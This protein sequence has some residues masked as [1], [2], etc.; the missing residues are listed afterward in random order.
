MKP[1]VRMN[2]YLKA[3]LLSLSIWI[4]AILM[5]TVFVMVWMHVFD[6]EELTF[7]MAG[8]IIYLSVVFSSPGFL[9][10]L[11][12]S[13]FQLKNKEL[14]TIL[15]VTAFLG[16]V[17]ACVILAAMFTAELNRLSMIIVISPAAVTLLSVGL[18]K[19]VIDI[20]TQKISINN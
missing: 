16:A 2:P 9:V 7:D 3:A 13:I 17:L 12:I 20:I 6:G 1:V 8:F 5:N 11:C 15:L 18:H 14:F 19:P 4:V 10:L